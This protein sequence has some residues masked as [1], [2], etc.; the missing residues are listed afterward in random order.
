MKQLVIVGCIVTLFSGCKI[1]EKKQQELHIVCSTSITR[2]C[3]QEIVGDVCEVKSLMG[4]GIDPHSYNPRPSDVSLLN[5]ATVVIYN[6]LHL[7]G[8]MAQLFH[9]LGERKTVFCVADGISKNRLISTDPSSGA[10]D[11]HIWFDT[12][13]WLQGLEQVTEDLCKAYPKYSTGF[14]ANFKRFREETEQLTVELKAEMQTVPRKQR[15]LITSHD[16]FHYFSRCFDIEVS[17]L[18]GISTTQEPGVQ[19]V[20]NLVNFIVNRRVKALF[21][22]HSVSPKAINTVM[23]SCQRKG[24]HVRVGGTLYSDALGDSQSKGNTYLNMLR[25]NVHTIIKGLK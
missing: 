5:D 15:V 8:K 6:G 11:P 12:E 25:H 17:A 13:S 18:Q 10:I 14:R 7:E 19:D 16:A 9:D 3:V 24:H 2:D 4:P 1:D 20:V 21:V 23:E 22:E